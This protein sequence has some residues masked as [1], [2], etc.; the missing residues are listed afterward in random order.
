MVHCRQIS[1]HNQTSKRLKYLKVCGSVKC[2]LQVCKRQQQNMRMEVFTAVKIPM[3]V[4]WVVT[5]RALV[6]RQT[7]T[8]RRNTLPPPLLTLVPTYKSRR[9]YDP[10]D[11]HPEQQNVAYEFL[12]NTFFRFHN[13]T[14]VGLEALQHMV[15]LGTVGSVP[16]YKR[17]DSYGK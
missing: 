5:P 7:L 15:I 12:M 1:Q 8:F 3:L 9:S 17:H 2:N 14:T 11:Q 6:G 13:W 4:F 16:C 10:E